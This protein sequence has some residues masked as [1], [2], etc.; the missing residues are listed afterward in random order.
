MATPQEIARVKCRDA[1]KRVED[2][3][4]LIDEASQILSNV[5]GCGKEWMALGKLYQKVRDL[6]ERLTYAQPIGLDH[7]PKMG[8]A[9]GCAKI[10]ET[11]DYVK[12]IKPL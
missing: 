7:E 2:A 1:A 11:I 8:C 6:W 10:A 5:T 4:A 3:Q 9:C 12:L